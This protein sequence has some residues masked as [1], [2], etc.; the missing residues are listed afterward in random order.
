LV[1]G[2]MGNR[3]TSRKR[4][5]LKCARVVALLALLCSVT[6]HAAPQWSLT[7][8]GDPALLPSESIN[9]SSSTRL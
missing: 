1:V 6:L 4:G 7:L 9:Q 5:T 2:E 3:D 8:D